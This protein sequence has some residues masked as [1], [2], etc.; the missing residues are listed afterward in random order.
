MGLT[1]FELHC[2]ADPVFFD[3]PGR[4]DDAQSLIRPSDLRGGVLRRDAADVWTRV[5]FPGS[6]A[7]PTQ[8]WKIHV[9]ATPT[10]A[11]RILDGA[12][13]VCAEHGMPYKFLRSTR[14]LATFNSKY[15]MRSS[16]GK[17]ITV[18][19]RDT[20]ELEV[21]GTALAEALKGEVGPYILSDLRWND[22]SPVFLR[23]G[24]FAPM[25]TP[26]SSDQPTLALLDPS[27][28]KVPDERSP[29]F[30]P[31]SWA[32]V[33][34]FVK[35]RMDEVATLSRFGLPYEIVSLLHFSVGGGVYLAKHHL[36]GDLVV[37]KEAR[38]YCG[39]DADGQD[40]VTRLRHEHEM[41][42]ALAPTGLVPRPLAFEQQ[43][44]HS[45]LVQEYIEGDTLAKASV[46]RNPLVRPDATASDYAQYTD[47]AT[48]LIVQITAA[49]ERIHE[50][51]H[52][53][54]DLHPNNVMVRPD[55]T[56]AFVDL[57][58]AHPIGTA[59]TGLIGAPGYAAP[60]HVQGQDIDRH[61]I[62]ALRI[63]LFIPLP[64]LSTA[65]PGKM[66]EL[67]HWAQERF[68][69]PHHHI[70]QAFT[71]IERITGRDAAS[72]PATASMAG[73]PWQEQRQALVAAI[74]ASA[75]PE[76]PD[77]LFPGDPAASRP[78]GALS[79]GH[80]A[81]G[82][83]YALHASG[84][85]VDEAWVDWLQS[86]AAGTINGPHPP[87]LFN[88]AA[89]AA[90]VLDLLG[91]TSAGHDLLK[92]SMAAC[93]DMSS[94]SL[95]T[96]LPGVGIALLRF[97]ARHGEPAH[98]RAAEQIAQRIRRILAERTETAHAAG[99]TAGSS[100][101]ALFL[102][103]LYRTTGDPALLDS[104]VECVRRDLRSCVEFNGSL[105]INDG[106][107]SVPYL[108]TGSTGIGI[109]ALECLRHR[110]EAD[111][112][113]AVEGIHRAAGNQFAVMPGL[114]QGRAGAAYYLGHHHPQAGADLQGHLTELWKY[115]VPHQGG[116]AFP[117]H[118]HLRLSMDLA[119]GT[120]GVLLAL[121]SVQRHIDHLAP[122]LGL[123]PGSA[124]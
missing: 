42:T 100:G 1:G 8:G 99:W 13:D 85:S 38:P 92:H 34:G 95:L 65:A 22:T 79:L 110:E 73:Q 112:R 19:P 23:Y 71:E 82:V 109:A 63:L 118:F 117:G 114:L 64:G 51:G 47:W 28:T 113:T 55:G 26:N 25:W 83:L 91:R 44:E 68:P 80:G 15:G 27:G 121:D 84:A 96:G 78:G 104:A 49:V 122:L 77:Q 58:A 50:A 97:F 107:R 18:Y 115:A 32:P 46:L 14:M 2:L 105:Q 3:S 12:A 98:L 101:A 61:G 56:L 31:P 62:A 11:Q 88:G 41:L 4:I 120:A 37:L 40:A 53:L 87:G 24:G 48:E 59:R 67:A 93:G 45:F 89:G 36:T 70:Q 16:A 69:L 74:A 5:E 9:S 21:L 54:G 81:A 39:L 57:E 86:A 29:A 17:F 52:V 108:G 10:H 116:L 111:L 94:L 7:L 123:S 76:R 43:W 30:R 33:P 35:R 20:D 119:T 90:V 103:N 6:R 60:V 102:T 66:A 106:W 75:T 124:A 72:G